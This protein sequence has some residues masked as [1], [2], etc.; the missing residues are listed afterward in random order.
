M[1]PT[2]TPPD[3]V[4]RAALCLAAACA[5]VAAAARPAAACASAYPPDKWVRIANESAVIVW[6]E[7][8][9]VEHFIRRATF[10]T[11]A[12]DFGFIV[13]TPSRPELGEIP[14]TLFQ[15]LDER[16]AP[17]VITQADVDDVSVGCALLGR[18][19]D[20][21]SS[22]IAAAPP[23]QVLETR[24][25][26]GYDVAV[27]EASSAVALAQWLKEH[28]YALRPSL[29]AWLA[30][31]VSAR[32]TIT[33]FKYAPG[34]GGGA[35]ASSAVRM[36]FATERPFFPYRE[37][38]DQREVPAGA[39]DAQPPARLLRIFFVGGGKVQG[40]LG[41]G[42]ERWP[43]EAV[44]A[45]AWPRD[46]AAALL[47]ALAGGIAQPWLTAFE[48]RSSPRPG[49]SDV[50][51]DPSG[52]AAP[53]HPEPIRVVRGRTLRLP[54]EPF[55]LAAGLALWLALRSPRAQRR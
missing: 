3:I 54:L 41:E 5:A 18:D 40:V 36:S 22:S 17:R 32:W 25:L 55:V 13:P 30:P 44:W 46:E 2:A 52:D 42:H 50:Y 27:L 43:G 53:L 37:P 45:D 19:S 4:R 26:A 11:T 35:V 47:G 23:V 1:N 31:Y 20:T 6:D 24:R 48:D 7:R 29:D 16:V 34:P 38:A 51:F 10:T 14:D 33:A 28:G 49:T 8:A 12:A 15:A 21:A 9:K 39:A